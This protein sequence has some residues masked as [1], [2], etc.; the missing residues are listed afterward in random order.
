M[1]YRENYDPY[2]FRHYRSEYYQPTP[3][4]IN[5]PYPMGQQEPNL[6]HIQQN[7][8]NHTYPAG[9]QGTNHPFPAVPQE[10]N[11]ANP[12]HQQEMNQGIQQN[13]GNHPSSQPYPAPNMGL[14]APLN[15]HSNQTAF[16]YFQKPEQP[17]NWPNNTSFDPAQFQQSPQMPPSIISQFQNENGQMD[18]DKVIGT[19]GQL[20]HTYH[21]VAPI[22]KQLGS[23]MKIFRTGG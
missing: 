4:Q 21:Q 10:E 15:E 18:V 17:M 9:P 14:Q 23:V 20:A 19:V 8:L 13:Q 12:L 6:S 1:Y 3:Q 7:Q 22:F 2:H 16:D 11:Y 5:H